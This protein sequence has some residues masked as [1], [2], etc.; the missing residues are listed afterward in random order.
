MEPGTQDSK[1]ALPAA[2]IAQAEAACVGNAD[3]IR[4]TQQRQSSIASRPHQATLGG[5]HSSAEA[6]R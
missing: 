6:P 2:I 1:D 4:S 5:A 3:E